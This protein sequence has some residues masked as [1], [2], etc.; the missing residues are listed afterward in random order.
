MGTGKAVDSPL[1]DVGTDPSITLVGRAKP[2]VG[3][4]SEQPNASPSESNEERKE[5][6]VPTREEKLR[7]AGFRRIRG[8]W[9]R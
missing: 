5:A 7:A 8:A 3:V 4:D 2:R 6:P 1:W 9:R